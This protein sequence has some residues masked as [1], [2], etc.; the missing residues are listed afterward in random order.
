MTSFKCAVKDADGLILSQCWPRPFAVPSISCFFL[1][2]NPSRPSVIA[3]SC[4]PC[5]ARPEMQFYFPS[6]LGIG[7]FYYPW[8]VPRMSEK[9][10]F[11]KFVERTQKGQLWRSCPKSKAERNSHGFD[12]M[13]R[14]KLL[15]GNIGIMQME[16]DIIPSKSSFG[17][18]HTG[19]FKL[20]D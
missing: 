10:N 18:S 12:M 6:V 15:Y 17:V 20:T 3:F 8:W 19:K 5:K 7:G 11:S 1:S 2:I 16:R 14:E 9:E 4:L 13:Y